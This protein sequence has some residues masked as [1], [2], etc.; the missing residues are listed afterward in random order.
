[1]KTSPPPDYRRL[2][3]LDQEYHWH[4]FTQMREWTRP[5]ADPLIIVRGEGALLYDAQGRAY[6]DGNSSIWTNL[7][8][9]RHPRLD[10]ALHAQLD[11]I[12]H[13]SALGLT[14]ELAPLLAQKLVAT[15]S[16]GCGHKVFFSDDG[17]T[18]IETAVKM[19]WQARQQRGETRRTR[20]LSL[21]GGYHGDTVGAM[22]IGQVP[23]FH[24]VFKG[25]LYETRALRMPNTYRHAF[26][27]TP[28]QRASGLRD[29]AENICAN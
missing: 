18:A 5:D 14:N 6:V 1:M 28:P 4:P 8:G 7:H 20:F 11:K 9:H 24:S 15:L 10:A 29:G 17:S 19:A 22:S 13:C 21:G 23:V 27:D 16:T 3:A 12:A 2:A 26:R 25:L